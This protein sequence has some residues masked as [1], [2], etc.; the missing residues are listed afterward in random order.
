[1][2]AI[3]ALNGATAEADGV[4]SLSNGAVYT[5]SDTPGRIGSSAWRN[6]STPDVQAL[7]ENRLARTDIPIDDIDKTTDAAELLAVYGERRTLDGGNLVDRSTIFS[8]EIS[9]EDGALV[10]VFRP[11]R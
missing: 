2:A 11:A 8:W 9:D 6:K 10:P 7:M 5:L 1:M 3:W 4:L